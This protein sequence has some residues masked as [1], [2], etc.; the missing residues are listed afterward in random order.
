MVRVVLFAEGQSDEKFIKESISPLFAASGLFLVP[1]LLKTSQ[2]ARGGAVTFDRL[3]LY[4]RNTL[5][6]GS[7]PILSTFL[8]L[9]ALDSDFPGY[10]EAKKKSDPYEKVAHLERE[11]HQS[12]VQLAGCQAER[13]IPH[14][15]PYEFEGL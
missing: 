7:A 10:E 2:N 8:D 1:R 9:Y 12:I 11:L 3:K 4:A 13:F 15:Q 5:R 14:I 6:E